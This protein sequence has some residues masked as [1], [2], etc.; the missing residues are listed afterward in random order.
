M[1]YTL[2]HAGLKI[3]ETAFEQKHARQRLGV[4]WPTGYG[5]EIFPRLSGILSAAAKLKSEMA[6]RGLRE[7]ELAENEELFV[8]TEGGRDMVE[9][10]RTLSE[11][12]LRD[13]KGQRLEFRSIAFS[14]LEELRRLC[15]QLATPTEM[16]GD[17]EIGET[18]PRYVVSV[19]LGKSPVSF[20]RFGMTSRDN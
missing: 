7:D 5:L 17:D 16:P 10:G 4:F 3:G 18:G 11:V 6:S 15:R 12:E 20:P 9:L 2:W 19:T 8:S 13:P 1:R 14:D